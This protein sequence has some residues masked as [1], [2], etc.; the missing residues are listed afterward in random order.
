[1]CRAQHS[2]EARG[3]EWEEWARK[4][5]ENGR[6]ETQSRRASVGQLG[7]HNQKVTADLEERV[8][9]GWMV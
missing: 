9:E 6:D 8:P 5:K 7:L 3:K 1:M 4:L 2:K